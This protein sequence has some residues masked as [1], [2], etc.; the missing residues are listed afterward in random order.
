MRV[1]SRTTSIVSREAGTT[2]SPWTERSSAAGRSAG[3]TQGGAAQLPAFV[4]RATQRAITRT[5][6]ASVR[7]EAHVASAGDVAATALSRRSRAGTVTAWKSRGVDFARYPRVL[8]LGQRAGE[9]LRDDRILSRRRALCY[10]N[11]IPW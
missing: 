4:S 10:S 8:F 6:A 9:F 3:A 11:S 5:S 1:V 2:A 7:R